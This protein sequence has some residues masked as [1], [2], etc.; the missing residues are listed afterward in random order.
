MV[1]VPSPVPVLV[2]AS[3]LPP[4]LSKTAVTDLALAQGHGASRCCP[5]QSPCQPTKT[6]PGSATAASLTRVGSG[7]VRPA[8]VGACLD[9]PA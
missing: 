6:E 9:A 7:I 2:K 1:S 5:R 3:S 4:M 8:T